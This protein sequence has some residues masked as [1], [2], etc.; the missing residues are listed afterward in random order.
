MKRVKGSSPATEDL[1]HAGTASDEL[2]VIVDAQEVNDGMSRVTE[3]AVGCDW[4]VHVP[5]V[6]SKKAYRTC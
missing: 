5:R 2:T 6:K 4:S 3:E 1:A